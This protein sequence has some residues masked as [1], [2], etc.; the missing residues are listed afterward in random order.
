MRREAVWVI[1]AVIVGVL[2]S[3]V[4]WPGGGTDNPDSY[5]YLIGG[6]S[7]WHGHGF[8]SMSG[9]DQVVFPPFY[10]L[11]IGGVDRVLH[12]PVLSGRLVSLLMSAASIA[13]LYAIA[14]VLI[15][16]KPA[17]VATWLFA[18]LPERVSLSSAVMSDVTFAALVLA[19][20]LLWMI[21]AS[22]PGV[23]L[24][25][26]LALGAAYLTRPEGVL[27]CGSLVLCSAVVSWQR[28]RGF[29][30]R[31]TLIILGFLPLLLPY[32]L[33]LHNHTGRWQLT[34]KTQVNLAR[35]S[36][37]TSD[38]EIRWYA[39]RRLSAD[40]T[41]VVTRGE[42]ETS[43]Q[44][45]LRVARNARSALRVLGEQSGPFLLVCVGLGLSAWWW[46]RQG[47]LVWPVLI[48]LASPLLF[49]P[50]FLV[51]GR[52]LLLTALV[53]ILLAVP[54]LAKENA[55]AEPSERNPRV[56]VAGLLM[57][58]AFLWMGAPTTL[59]LL[60]PPRQPNAAATMLTALRRVPGARGPVIGN[61]EVARALA[62]ETGR[63]HLLL[64]WEPLSRVLHYADIHQA[65]LLLLRT[66]D[67][68]ELA[69]LV[70]HPVATERLTP[71]ARVE[72]ALGQGMSAQQLYLIRPPQSRPQTRADESR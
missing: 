67:Y 44:L 39:S 31:E 58:G 48:T 28:R 33:Y 47:D 2:L 22:R 54:A 69:A 37:L 10:P 25:C 17:V 40:D 70:E 46:R 16:G 21:S 15:P 1:A 66:A 24:A 20:I 13:L 35:G 50:F 62:F 5:E 53:P 63:C 45:A 7:L 30:L 68:P 52:F 18:F 56:T 14:R 42:S 36:T 27:L 8:R 65:S 34:A 64:P 9:G 43:G 55:P 72:T 59:A 38:G 32:V 57:I 61:T 6:L 29:P 26:G 41:T 11:L 12:D 23:S 4:Y 71:L 51:A 60:A 3:L 49:L 19:G